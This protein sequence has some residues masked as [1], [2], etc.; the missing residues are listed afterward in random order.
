[1]TKEN[2]DGKEGD[3][4]EVHRNDLD[5]PSVHNLLVDSRDTHLGRLKKKRK[6]RKAR[7]L[8]KRRG[9]ELS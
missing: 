6:F 1:M 7:E 4:A 2:Q 9:E 5:V 3:N 8:R